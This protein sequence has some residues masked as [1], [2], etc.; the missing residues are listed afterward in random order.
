MT[1]SQGA[2]PNMVYLGLC[3]YLLRPAWYQVG[4]TAVS[5]GKCFFVLH[6]SVYDKP[7]RNSDKGESALRLLTARYLYNDGVNVSPPYPCGCIAPSSSIDIL[8]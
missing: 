4:V 3:E 1:L 8:I 6:T 5:L 7:L 2:L